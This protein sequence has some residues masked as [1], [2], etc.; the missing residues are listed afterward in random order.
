DAMHNSGWIAG[1][2]RQAIASTIGTGLMLAAK[3][4]VSLF[5]GDRQADD[6]WGQ[7]VERAFND[8]ANCPEECDAAGKHTLGQMTEAAL[9]SNFAYSEILAL[10][11]MI[12]RPESATRIKLKLLPPHKLVQDTDGVRLF[13]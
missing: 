13:Q 9:R 3:P 6:A 12:N 2:V 5:G 8:W 1:M 7:Q 10:L 4:E 11:P